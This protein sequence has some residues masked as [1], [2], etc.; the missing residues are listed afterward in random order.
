MLAP[1]LP[2]WPPPKML[3]VFVLEPKPGDA[4]GELDMFDRRGASLVVEAHR[5]LGHEAEDAG[6]QKEK[7]VYVPELG[8]LL[9]APNPPKVDCC[10]CWLL[11]PKPPKPP[12]PN[13]MVEVAGAGGAWSC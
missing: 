11:E 10:C 12:D 9:F 6:R 5:P 13:D 3:P 2:D 8:L 7:C 1:V 4:E